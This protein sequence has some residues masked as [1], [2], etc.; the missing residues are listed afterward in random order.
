MTKIKYY[1]SEIIMSIPPGIYWPVVIFLILFLSII[2]GG[3][4]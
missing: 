3:Q 4:N 1:L 2:L